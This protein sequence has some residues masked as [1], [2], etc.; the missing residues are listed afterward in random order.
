MSYLIE[1]GLFF[2]FPLLV[3]LIFILTICTIAIIKKKNVK[4]IISLINTVGVFAMVWGFLGQIIGFL[5][6]FEA[7]EMAGD[8]SPQV[9]AAGLRISFYAPI[10]GIIIF[11]I[12]KIEI[13]I[14][15]WSQKE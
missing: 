10:F 14:L 5:G 15:T 12:S 13:F 6:A 7:I 11:L 2:M 9:M 1:G 8:I 4:R 3:L